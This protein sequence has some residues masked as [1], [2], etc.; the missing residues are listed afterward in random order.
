MAS[1]F[2]NYS[3]L[4]TIE[5]LPGPGIWQAGFLWGSDEKAP[6]VDVIPQPLDE[7]TLP[8]N[9]DAVADVW[10]G[11]L[12]L[13]G[14]TFRLH[15]DEHTVS[16]LCATQFRP[17]MT[18]LSTISSVN[19]TLS[20]RAPNALQPGD[21]IYIGDETLIVQ[22]CSPSGNSVYSAVVTRG[23]AGSTARE[24]NSGESVYTSPPYHKH[25]EMKLEL[26]DNRT[27]SIE[28]IWRGILDSIRTD[29][30]QN[31][32]EVGG[33]DPLAAM[34][35]AKGGT[36]KIWTHS[37][38]YNGNGRFKN[39]FEGFIDPDGTRGAQQLG[40]AR[41]FRVGETLCRVFPDAGGLEAY[42]IGTAVPDHDGEVGEAV[43]ADVTVRELLCL[44]R[45]PNSTRFYH[46]DF[47]KLVDLQDHPVAIALALLTS[48]GTGN[49]GPFDILGRDWGLGI[50]IDYIDLPAWLELISKYPE[51][52]DQLFLN[53]D[54]KYSFE[55]VVLN[56]LLTPFNFRPVP[57]P[58]GKITLKYLSTWSIDM[59]DDVA[60]KNSFV[61]V[62]PQGL[63]MD[64][65][66]NEA[67]GR[68]RGKLGETPFGIDPLVLTVSEMRGNRTDY[69]GNAATT[70]YDFSTI[71]K[72][73][74]GE[75]TARLNDLARKR[76]ENWPI[77]RCSVPMHSRDSYR[78]MA[79][80]G[81]VPGLLDWCVITSEADQMP[82]PGIIAP[83]GK[84]HDLRS[85]DITFIGQIVGR[86]FNFRDMSFDLEVILTSWG[87]GERPP[88]LI[89]PCDRITSIDS[90]GE[91]TFAGDYK[92]LDGKP[93][94]NP[95]GDQVRIIDENGL[96]HWTNPS[97]VMFLQKTGS[98][99]KLNTWTGSIVQAGDNLYLRYDTYDRY[100]NQYLANQFYQ[101][102]VNN[103]RTAFLS[104][105]FGYLGQLMDEGDIYG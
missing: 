17:R 80:P 49:N 81:R 71:Q 102:I 77:L 92:T 98:N 33:S 66:V 41:M 91:I 68:V 27:G 15:A 97:G 93:G 101:I 4:L 52:I 38:K 65:R 73:R 78:G 56:Q 30:H 51:R 29:A 31:Q 11:Q 37:L 7:T 50:S 14:A 13:Q 89:A 19:T 74:S 54:D 28:V 25:R 79:G 12:G 47:S 100:N 69:Q 39:Y 64:F 5:G 6:I 58:D 1:P 61:F 45:D 34:L 42:F 94:Y 18:L 40:L 8:E 84:K 88:M 23:K 48:T 3:L 90:T 62:T 96:E 44:W 55:D 53:W 83:D 70:E 22:S 9:L 95:D 67:F 105:D 57:T 16:I 20:I 36:D 86:T 24:H 87:L 59:I 26:I 2:M 104:D 99:W 46:N 35:G 85:F 82:R 43:E 63:E 76:R 21:K 72:R 75:F 32:I 10:T 60:A 103:R